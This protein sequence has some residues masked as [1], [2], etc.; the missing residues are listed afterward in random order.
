MRLH[1]H[2]IINGRTIRNGFE[3]AGGSFLRFLLFSEPYLRAMGANFAQRTWLPR[4]SGPKKPHR[5]GPRGLACRG[6]IKLA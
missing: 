1:A 2:I 3:S 6:A 5:A 4:E